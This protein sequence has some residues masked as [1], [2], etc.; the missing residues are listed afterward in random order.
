VSVLIEACVDS[1]ES[2][3]A[4]V[5][6]GA[7]RLELCDNLAVGGTTPSEQLL[8]TVKER[9]PIPV[10]AM[11]RPRG[12]PF[13]HSDD[14]LAHMHRDI[15]RVKECGADG[16]V[17]GVLDRYNRIDLARTRELAKLAAGVPVTFH[18]AFDRVPDKLAALD[19]LAG[20][21][22]ERVL[23]SGGP[24]TAQEGASML[25]QL[26]DHAGDR[27]VVLAGGNVRAHNVRD[28]VQRTGVREVHARCELD[29]ARITGI[30]RALDE[31][32]RVPLSS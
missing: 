10:F 28:L 11:I 9:I 1:I 15:G 16:I 17:I 21:G 6:G 20:A 25:A 2:A 18:R 30:R 5:E 23:T 13:V 3:L 14:E 32:R 12:G 29:S 19:I 31:P 7:D 26:V 22:V 8:R 24:A 27:I 4:A